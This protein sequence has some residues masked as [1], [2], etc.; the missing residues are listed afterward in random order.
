VNGT[1]NAPGEIGDVGADDHPSWGYTIPKHLKEP[2]S[3]TLHLTENFGIA[4]IEGEPIEEVDI[5]PTE[6]M[7]AGVPLAVDAGDQGLTTALVFF[8]CKKNI[9]VE[10]PY[11]APGHALDLEG[12]RS[13]GAIMKG[14]EFRVQGFEDSRVQVAVSHAGVVMVIMFVVWYTGEVR[15]NLI[16]LQHNGIP[17]SYSGRQQSPGMPE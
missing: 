6:N 10:V 13:P 7:T 2:F 3:Q 1:F 4:I 12:V 11:P 5:K 9:E 8:V 17:Y 16:L 14:C 15:H